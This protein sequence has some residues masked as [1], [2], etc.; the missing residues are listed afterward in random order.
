MKWTFTDVQF[1][2]IGWIPIILFKQIENYIIKIIMTDIPGSRPK[3]F[4]KKT[5]F[6]NPSLY[7]F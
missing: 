6:S 4:I 2:F 1:N 5:N 3:K 7:L